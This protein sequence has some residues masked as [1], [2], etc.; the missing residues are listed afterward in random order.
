M[1]PMPREH[2]DTLP[3]LGRKV[4]AIAP[5]PKPHVHQWLAVPDSKIHSRCAECGAVTLTEI[6]TPKAASGL[7][8][9][10]NAQAMGPLPTWVEVDP[11]VSG[12]DKSS[13]FG[14]V[15]AT[16]FTKQ[17][18]GLYLNQEVAL[19]EPPANKTATEVMMKARASERRL[20]AW[21][22]I[23]EAF[24]KSQVPEIKDSA[25]VAAVR[26]FFAGSAD[27]TRAMAHAR[28]VLDEMGCKK[29]VE[30]PQHR[31]AEFLETLTTGPQRHYTSVTAPDGKVRM[32]ETDAEGWIKN[33]G[34]QP[35]ADGVRVEVMSNGGCDRDRDYACAYYW[36]LDDAISHWRPA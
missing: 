35:V 28:S 16:D 12:S 19:R 8:T 11:A 17:F 3:A 25:L 31:R 29:T 7:A 23:G 15:R 22:E 6:V 34:A 1:I 36:G 4:V 2:T 27:R 26:D 13:V 24:A 30:V 20:A 9:L 33:D 18:R 5:A 32:V 14:W 10:I 21:A